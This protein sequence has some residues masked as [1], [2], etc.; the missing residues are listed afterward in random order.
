MATVTRVADWDYCDMCA[1][2]THDGER[3]TGPL[4]VQLE[5]STCAACGWIHGPYL[6]D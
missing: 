5:V 3:Y 4:G 1:A 6:A 2:T